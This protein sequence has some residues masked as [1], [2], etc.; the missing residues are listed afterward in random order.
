[1]R[2]WITEV[3]AGASQRSLLTNIYLLL[4]MYKIFNKNINYSGYISFKP[5]VRIR[6][7]QVYFY[8]VL[9]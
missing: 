9:N 3:V 6:P 2:L 4:N 7:V 8:K 5:V 1:M